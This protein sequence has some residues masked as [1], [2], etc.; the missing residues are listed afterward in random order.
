VRMGKHEPVYCEDIPIVVSALTAVCAATF[1]DWRQR[2]FCG[3][4]QIV[5]TSNRPWQTLPFMGSGHAISCNSSVG[6]SREYRLSQILEPFR[7]AIARGATRWL[8]T[9]NGT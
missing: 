7:F 4:A 5:A 3:Y 2:A 6:E 8:W 1:S 9:E